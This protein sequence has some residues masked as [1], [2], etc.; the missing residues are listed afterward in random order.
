MVVFNPFQGHPLMFFR[1]GVCSLLLRFAAQGP[2]TSVPSHGLVV[3]WPWVR[4][5][6][7]SK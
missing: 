2:R 5:S 7:E 1:D 4:V 3:R 6:S